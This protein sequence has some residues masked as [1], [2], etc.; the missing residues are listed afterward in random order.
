[1]FSSTKI[2]LATLGL[3]FHHS[4]YS[5]NDFSSDIF[6]ITD[7]NYI[8]DQGRV[9]HTIHFKAFSSTG[10]P[11]IPL[12]DNGKGQRG[13]TNDRLKVRIDGQ[14]VAFDFDARGF[15]GGNSSDRPTHRKE[16]SGSSDVNASVYVNFLL[17]MSGS[18]MGSKLDRAKD[19]IINTLRDPNLRGATFYLTLFDNR[20][21]S[22]I[23]IS[24]NQ[25]G[26]NYIK[27]LTIEDPGNSHTDLYRS[28][29]RSA[30]IMGQLIKSQ[31]FQYGNNSTPISEAEQKSKGIIVLLTDGV[32]DIKQIWDYDPS[33][34]VTEDD[35]LSFLKTCDPN[36]MVYTV[37]IGRAPD[38]E[39]LSSV[40]ASTQN[41]NDRYA[42]N[43]E[44]SELSSVLGTIAISSSNVSNYY[45][46]IK[47][48]KKR[49]HSES[50][51]VRLEYPGRG[52]AAE[53]VTVF[54]STPL[55]YD[56][57]HAMVR[58]ILIFVFLS[59]AIILILAIV[60]PIFKRWSFDSKHFMRLKDYDSTGRRYLDAV[61]NVL[62]EPDEKVI[63]KCGGFYTVASWKDSGNKCIKCDGTCDYYSSNYKPKEFFSQRGVLALYNW[64]WFGTL[65]GGAGNI[66]LPIRFSCRR[67][68][69]ASFRRDLIRVCIQVFSTFRPGN[70]DRSQ[71]WSRARIGSWIHRGEDTIE[72]AIGLKNLI[73]RTFGRSHWGRIV[74]CHGLWSAPCVTKIRRRLE[75]FRYCYFIGSIGIGYRLD[76]KHFLCCSC[77]ER[78]K[79]WFGRRTHCL[80]HLF[81]F[82]HRCVG[83]L[84]GFRGKRRMGDEN[85][86]NNGV[87]RYS[88]S[89]HLP[90]FIEIGE[91]PHYFFKSLRIHGY[92]KTDRKVVNITK[93][94]WR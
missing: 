58:P 88:W 4:V 92:S 65:G 94:R 19:G 85:V 68:I 57:W 29:L 17:D 46:R 40:V 22:P 5:Q 86:V 7:V 45:V 2:L 62:L 18:M 30:E 69:D 1:M 36:L 84:Y 34:I 31:T 16:S 14:E 25:D 56:P 79:R 51:K 90:G 91:L 6:E 83:A 26:I 87:R 50:Y 71:F 41:P 3:L 74:R 66:Y 15:I 53:F 60:F 12:E 76:H 20:P 59:A 42:T 49:Y 81:H 89:R 37:G 39:F 67:N 48:L 77:P 38:E 82:E 13:L 73:Q 10:E 43:I 44:S 52:G 75:V 23:E 93:L 11:L 61:F 32:N 27:S 8:E 28:L 9:F 35:V 64:I 47:P 24:A 21:N 54:P 33:E 70:S 72:E 80:K 55:L 78:L 63:K